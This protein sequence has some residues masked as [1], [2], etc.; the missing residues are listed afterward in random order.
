MMELE[1]RVLS[2]RQM[3]RLY[4]WEMR[5]AF[6]RVELKPLWTI[7]R[8]M[9]RGEYDALGFYRGEEL[10]GYALLRLGERFVLLDY[11]G[12]CQGKRGMGVGSAMLE[13]LRRRYAVTAGLL[14][15]VET[16]E[17]ALPP[18]EREKRR[19]RLAFYTRNGFFDLNYQADIFRVRYTMLGWSASGPTGTGE[20]M[21]AHR[22]LYRLG[23]LLPLYRR[24]VHIPIQEK[25]GTGS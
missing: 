5:E 16:I 8:L 20:A 22:A 6:P 11:L 17:A 1:L 15:E 3:R 4:R 25:E 18:E 24:Y 19:R 2:R 10:M 12:A 7:L 14:A 13:Q 23:T 21:E 9:E